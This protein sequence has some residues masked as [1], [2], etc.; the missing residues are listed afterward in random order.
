MRIKW[1]YT[2]LWRQPRIELHRLFREWMKLHKNSACF[3]GRTQ[4]TFYYTQ[5]ERTSFHYW[6]AQFCYSKQRKDCVHKT[7]HHKELKI[8]S[9]YSVFA[10][11][12]LV[13][14]VR[15]FIIRAGALRS[16]S[17]AHNK[18]FKNNSKKRSGVIIKIIM[19]ALGVERIRWN[20][21][22][23]TRRSYITFLGG[24]VATAGPWTAREQSQAAAELIKQGK[25]AI[26]LTH[27]QHSIHALSMWRAKT[28]TLH[29][30]WC[31]LEWR[32]SLFG[33]QFAHA[34]APSCIE[35]GAH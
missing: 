30:L 34:R 13:M 23:K 20:G 12:A 14:L 28:L 6:E 16:Y 24:A 2:V 3:L 5:H 26:P 4:C 15:R 32:C 9:F 11:G 35:K 31:T 25:I 8:S 19:A 1:K 17:L 22:I 21:K 10:M 33:Q 18:M 27:N 29:M 7:T